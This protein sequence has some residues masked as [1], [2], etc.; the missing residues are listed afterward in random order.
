LGSNLTTTKGSEIYHAIK[1]YR[2]EV[3]TKGKPTYW[4]TDLN[5][6]PDLIDFFMSKNLSFGFLDVTDGF[7]LDSDHS[8]IVLTLS[9]TI[10]KKGRNPTLTNNLTDWDLF[11]A[12]LINRIN[13]GVALS[14]T[15][16]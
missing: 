2:C 5:K 9:E 15:D 3:H 8:P 4:P 11:Q 16:E 14:T 1:E 12:S 13:L 6:I 10:I 7:D